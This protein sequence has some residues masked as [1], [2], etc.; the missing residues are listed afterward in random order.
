ML[1]LRLAAGL[2]GAFRLTREGETVRDPGWRVLL[3][4][5]LAVIHLQ[6][7]V[8]LKSHRDIR[9]PLTCGFIRPVVLIPDGHEAWTEEQRSSTLIHELSHIKRA[10]FLVMVLVRVSLALFWWNPL[11]WITYRGLLKEQELA[12]DELVLRAGIRPSTYAASLLAFGRSAGF[13]WD[14]SAALL[15]M[16]GRSSLQERLAAILR[17]KLTFM[18]VKMKTKITMALALVAAMALIGT[19]RPADGRETVEATAMIAETAIAVP[20]SLEAVP[21]DAGSPAVAAQEKQEEMAAVQKKEKDK[22]AVGKKILVTAK[23]G[24][25]KAITITIT[26]GDKVKT[27]VLDKPLTITKDGEVLILA[28]EGKE[29]EVLEGEPLRLEIEGAGL[30]VL[31]EGKALEIDK[32]LREMAAAGV[33]VAYHCCDVADRAALAELSGQPLARILNQGLAPGGT[34]RPKLLVGTGLDRLGERLQR[35]A[36]ALLTAG[37]RPEAVGPGRI[38]GRHVHP[39]G[40]R[41]YRNFLLLQFWPDTMPYATADTGVQLAHAVPA[42]SHSQAQHSHVELM[43]V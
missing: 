16:L 42:V 40:N 25:N 31:R 2:F 27:I 32:N 14:P 4:R 37:A 13:R 28:S 7:K 41:A 19:A 12:C 24:E 35:S 6:R 39:V 21:A 20:S 33:N 30:T 29:I 22:I 5:F 8:R 26:E 15:G 10:D 38:P 9:I 3:E 23:E 18:E 11:C 43:A 1:L 34:T 36:P 17:Q